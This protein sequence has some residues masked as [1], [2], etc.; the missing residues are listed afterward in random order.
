MSTV[1]SVRLFKTGMRA[2]KVPATTLMRPTSV[3]AEKSWPNRRSVLTSR[4]SMR[5]SLGK[6]RPKQT[7]PKQSPRNPVSKGLQNY[8]ARPLHVLEFRADTEVRWR[9]AISY[10]CVLYM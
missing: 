10:V 6:S 8:R 9:R 7:T 4:C 2:E 1:S 3:K 5:F